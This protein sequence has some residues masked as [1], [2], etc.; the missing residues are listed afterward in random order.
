[1]QQARWVN[2]RKLEYDLYTHNE[3][4]FRGR[5]GLVVGPKPSGFGPESS[6]FETLFHCRSAA[7]DLLHSKSCLVAKRPPVCV[8][9]KFGEGVPAQVSFS[10]SDRGSKLRGLSQNSPRVASKRGITKTKLI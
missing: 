3:D 7:W 9:W 1:M 8:A 6:K 2:F 5:G 10:S 4:Q